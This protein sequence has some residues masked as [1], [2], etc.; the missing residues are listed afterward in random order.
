MYDPQIPQ[1]EYEKYI[2]TECY[3]FGTHGEVTYGN[4]GQYWRRTVIIAP[5]ILIP[6]LLHLAFIFILFVL[7]RGKFLA[8]D[9]MEIFPLMQYMPEKP[10]TV[11]VCPHCKRVNVQAKIKDK[12]GQTALHFHKKTGLHLRNEPAEKTIDKER[13]HNPEEF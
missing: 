4:W 1:L 10:H 7:F 9:T 5:I 11:T 3:Q 8:I 6:T 2:C 13:K 12:N